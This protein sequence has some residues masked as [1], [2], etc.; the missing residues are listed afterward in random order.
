MLLAVR[1]VNKGVRG[2]CNHT[3]R[4]GALCKFP[5]E[6]SSGDE[7]YYWKCAE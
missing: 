4:C 1:K 3:G 6:L 2:T 5:C 7:A